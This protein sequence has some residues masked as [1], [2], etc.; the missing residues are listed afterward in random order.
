MTIQVKKFIIYLASAVLLGGC[1]TTG[2]W[3]NP[4]YTDSINRFL[5]TE[6]GKNFIFLGEKYHY[7]FNDHNS[8]R[9]IL[10][11]KDRA[12]LEAI[13]YEKFIIDSSNNISGNLRI[14]CKC[15]NATATQISWVKKIGFIKLPTSDVQLYSL[16]GIE[17]EELYILVIRLSGVR[18]LAKDLALDKYAKLNKTYKVVIEEP[19][20]T[21]GVIGRVLLTPIT[22][23]EDGIAVIGLTPIVAVSLPFV[24]VGADFSK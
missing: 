10:L 12:V 20:S 9:Q 1:S 8:L 3:Q 14:I 11:W 6:D 7:I 4:T 17:T 19:K 5:A 13:F 24:L 23:V 18:Y 16:M 15:K 21:S 22:V 2:L